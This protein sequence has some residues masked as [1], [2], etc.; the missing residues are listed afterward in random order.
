MHGIFV[1]ASKRWWTSQV[2]VCT[3]NEC[4]HGYLQ[5]QLQIVLDVCAAIV[6]CFVI[7]TRLQ[8]V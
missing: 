2:T 3:K 6:V 8:R 5:N 1:L 4:Y 7:V